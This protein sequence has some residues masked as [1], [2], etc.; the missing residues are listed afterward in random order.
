[1]RRLLNLTVAVQAAR[2]SGHVVAV[3]T[4]LNNIARWRPGRSP[5]R[6]P[7]G[8]ALDPAFRE[9]VLTLPSETM[10]AEQMDVI[11]PHAIHAARQF[12]RR[13]LARELRDDLLAAYHAN[14][15]PGAYSPDAALPAAAP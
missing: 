12:L 7:Q 11:D 9:L 6:H 4:V 1:M 15:T 2:Q 8:R 13:S 14:Q 3:D 10:I 5:A